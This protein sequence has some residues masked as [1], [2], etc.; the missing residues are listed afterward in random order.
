MNTIVI[1]LIYVILLILLAGS[2]L[3]TTWIIWFAF[4]VG[5]FV[6]D[7]AKLIIDL[8]NK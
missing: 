6:K 1:I 7:I 2:K 3:K 8:I 5:Y 4:T